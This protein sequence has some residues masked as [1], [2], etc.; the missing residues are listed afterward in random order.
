[1]CVDRQRL[2]EAM[3]ND[4]AGGQFSSRSSSQTAHYHSVQCQYEMGFLL[5]SAFFHGTTNSVKRYFPAVCDDSFP[6]THF[7][8]ETDRERHRSC[9]SASGLHSFVSTCFDASRT[10]PCLST[11]VDWSAFKQTADPSRMPPL[12]NDDALDPGGT[13]P[14]NS[15]S[16]P[17]VCIPDIGDARSRT[18]QTQTTSGQQHRDDQRVI[19]AT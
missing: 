14:M 13:Q 17:L 2:V 6:L 5:L 3:Q 18:R 15:T 19:A 4:I 1:M 16:T 12:L 9:A 8:S 7:G 10:L 11:C